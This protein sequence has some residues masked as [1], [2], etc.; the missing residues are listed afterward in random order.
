MDKELFEEYIDLLDQV[1]FADNKVAIIK[2]RISELEPQIIEQ[3]AEMGLDQIKMK[4]KLLYLHQKIYPKW[5]IDDKRVAIQ[6][7]KDAG[8]GD[9][10]PESIIA[11]KMAA[12]LQELYD[13]NDPIPESL[14]DVVDFNPV[15][16]IGK[17]KA[18]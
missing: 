8:L 5:K 14:A 2:E 1:K 15:N 16:K 11:S 10:C 12:Y 4:G 17:R 3:M 13:N 9:F 18:V 6:A 7:L